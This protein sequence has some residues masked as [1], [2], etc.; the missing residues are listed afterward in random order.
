V[1]SVV[2][3]QRGSDSPKL[4]I[5][6][7]KRCQQLAR[8]SAGGAG[9]S[10]RLSVYLSVEKPDVAAMFRRTMQLHYLQA[11]ELNVER[12]VPEDRTE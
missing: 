6:Y 8:Y 7:F 2:S 5:N 4:K 10:A 1:K 9:G 3:N 11:L 12:A